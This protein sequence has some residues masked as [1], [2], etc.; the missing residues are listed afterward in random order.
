MAV[1]GIIELRN[2]AGSST[3]SLDTNPCSHDISNYDSCI[4]SLENQKLFNHGKLDPNF[5]CWDDDPKATGT[6]SPVRGP[7]V[8]TP[9]FAS[10]G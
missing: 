6:Y 10:P 1:A 8:L 9:Q 5:C 2:F 4:H 7:E 3:E